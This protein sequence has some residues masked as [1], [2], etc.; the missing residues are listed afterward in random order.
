VTADPGAALFFPPSLL[1]LPA[2]RVDLA[3]C[4]VLP[5]PDPDRE[6]LLRALA[7]PSLFLA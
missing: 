6:I 1:N 2:M 5:E 7:G 3:T 4:R